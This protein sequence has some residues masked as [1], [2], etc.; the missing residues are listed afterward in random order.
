M[1]NSADPDQLTGFAN[2]VVC[3]GRE[4]PGSPEPGICLYPCSQFTHYTDRCKCRPK[5]TDRKLDLRTFLDLG[6]S[7]IFINALSNL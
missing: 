7:E 1:T 3:K 6:E 5:N 4:Y 2:N